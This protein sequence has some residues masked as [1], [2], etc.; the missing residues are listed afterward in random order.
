MELKKKCSKIWEKRKSCDEAQAEKPREEKEAQKGSGFKQ[1]KNAK[2]GK[3][4]KEEKGEEQPQI[5]RDQAR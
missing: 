3:I 1:R 5:W 4:T 2:M